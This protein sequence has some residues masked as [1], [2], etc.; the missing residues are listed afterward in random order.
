MRFW[1]FCNS[2][3]WTSSLSSR[4]A[5]TKLE[6]WS[7]H[8]KLGLPRQAM[9]RLN[10]AIKASVLRSLILPTQDAQLLPIG[11][12]ICKHMVGLH[13]N[14]YLIYTSP[15]QSTPTQLNTESGVTRSIGNWPIIKFWGQGC[16]EVRW[17]VMHPGEAEQGGQPPP[18]PKWRA[19]IL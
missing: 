9:K 16:A 3:N 18:P 5:P 4:A 6:P 17:Q 15:A 1:V 11:I 8:I 14:P 2:K 19:T 12:Q 7:L 10:K 13:T